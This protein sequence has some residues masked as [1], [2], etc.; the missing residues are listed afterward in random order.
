MELVAMAMRRNGVGGG[1]CA[2]ADRGHNASDAGFCASSGSCEKTEVRSAR[3][4]APS[5]G[6]WRSSALQCLHVQFS[7]RRKCVVVSG[8]ITLLVSSL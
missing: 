8:L 6:S 5:T 3:R 4:T 1:G 2:E 7:W